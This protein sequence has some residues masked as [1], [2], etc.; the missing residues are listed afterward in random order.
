MKG[1]AAMIGA[2]WLAGSARILEYAARDR[3]LDQIISLTPDFIAEWRSYH[4]KLSVCMK[5]TPKIPVEHY[6]TI[7]SYLDALAPAMEDMD[8]DTLDETMEQLNRYS[9]PEELEA[10]MGQLDTAIANLDDA[11]INLLLTD[12]RAMISS[13]L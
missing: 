8:L 13:F 12:I 4:D 6:N 9:Y 2:V 1:S 3:K 10:L 11:G 7:L 5:E